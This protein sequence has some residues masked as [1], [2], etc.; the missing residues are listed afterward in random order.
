MKKIPRNCIFKYKFR[1]IFLQKPPTRAFN[2]A[3]SGEIIV[4]QLRKRALH[5]LY[6]TLPIHNSDNTLLATYFRP[7]YFN[8]LNAIIA[9]K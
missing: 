4:L 9:K 7:A 3:F 1:K 5:M 8:Y 2:A 6:G